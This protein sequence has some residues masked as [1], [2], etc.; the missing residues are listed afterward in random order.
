MKVSELR[1]LLKNCSGTAVSAALVEVYREVP[2][3]RK[4]ELDGKIRAILAGEKPPA[5]TPPAPKNSILDFGSLK[6]EIQQFVEDV[7]GGLYCLPNRE[8]PQWRFK[9]MRF[10]RELQ[11]VTPEMEFCDEAADLFVSLYELLCAGCMLGLFTSEDPFASIRRSQED[12]YG[13][14][15]RLVLS[16]G[17]TSGKA[18]RLILLS[19]TGGL[20]QDTAH[21]DVQKALL[22]LLR[23]DEERRTVMATAKSLC[24]TQFERTLVYITGHEFGSVPYTVDEAVDDLCGLACLAACQL[25]GPAP[26]DAIDFFYTHTREL[27]LE[28][29][30]HSVLQDTGSTGLWIQLY[31]DGL[32]RGIT[33]RE[34]LQKA[35]AEK[36]AEL[37]G[38]N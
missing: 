21:R 25:G 12:V 26:L 8:R 34:E 17:F 29:V 30:L 6:K 9:V 13:A 14:M 5:G 19:S 16:T 27:S 32:T 3:G 1:T 7:Y 38:Q 28:G 31:E 37:Q 33:P 36:K 2:R 35:Y 22:P 20:S 15:A 11:K 10:I 23:N 24:T 4:P 18:E